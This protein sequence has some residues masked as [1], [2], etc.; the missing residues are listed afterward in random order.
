MEKENGNYDLGSRANVA[1]FR[2]WGLGLRVFGG[3]GLESLG[4]RVQ[5]VWGLVVGI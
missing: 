1:G 4:I 3:Y 5:S 2:V